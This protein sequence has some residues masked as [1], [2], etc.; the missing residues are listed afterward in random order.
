MCI[1]LW[2][3]NSLHSILASVLCKKWSNIDSNSMLWGC[4]V[5]ISIRISPYYVFG[6]FRET[7]WYGSA[8]RSG[9][10]VNKIAVTFCTSTHLLFCKL[11]EGIWNNYVDI[12]QKIMQVRFIIS[13]CT[14]GYIYLGDPTRQHEVW[15]KTRLNTN[16]S[17]QN[18]VKRIFLPTKSAAVCLFLQY[19]I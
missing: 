1:H 2:S 3:S 19:T 15:R 13:L 6:N 17:N 4:A 7:M 11:F 16:W 9:D 12:E 5:V 18:W 8:N 14:W 10:D